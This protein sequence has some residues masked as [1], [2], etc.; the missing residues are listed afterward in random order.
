M[1]AER[2]WADSLT[3]RTLRILGHWGAASLTGRLAQGAA[4]CLAAG[5]RGSLLGRLLQADLSGSRA[6]EGSWVVAAFAGAGR[7]VE[8]GAE[9][10]ASFFRR[11]AACSYVGQ[12]AGEIERQAQQG[13]TAFWAGAALGL[14]L[15]IVLLGLARGGLTPARQAVAG[16]L[17]AAA[18]LL[19]AGPGWLETSLVV[20]FGRW[21]L[22]LGNGE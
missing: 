15:G 8:R 20:R 11:A 5:W 3:G 2:M 14:G 7:W 1:N 10:W 6:L 9:R 19:W 12:A 4:A 22:D 17:A 18:V 16:T 13:G 21:L